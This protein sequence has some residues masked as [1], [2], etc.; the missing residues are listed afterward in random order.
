M[1]FACPSL[2]LP[3]VDRLAR[4]PQMIKGIAKVLT[5][6]E[7]L[8][9]FLRNHFV[10]LLNS[11]DRKMLH[12]DDLLLRKQALN[13]IEMLIRMMGSHLNTYVPKLMVL[14]LHAIDKESLQLEGLSVLHFF[15]KQLSEVSPSSIKHIISQVFASL[16]PFL[17]RD[18][19]N[20]SIHLGKVVKILE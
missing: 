18:K 5:G 13:R 10:F 15:I 20:P 1:S 6:A 8:P 7:D 17:E 4:V 2:I 19:E 3:F 14:L 12:S 9:G 16:L 11:I